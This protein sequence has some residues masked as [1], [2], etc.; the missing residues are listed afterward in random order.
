MKHLLLLNKLRVENAN[1]IAGMTWG[2]PAP[3][4][5]LGFTHALSRKCQAKWGAQ[6]SL[7]GVGIICHH[8]QVHSQQ[9]SGFE[10]VFA[11]SRNPLTKDGKTAPFNEEGRM[12]MTVSLLVECEFDPLE[13]ALGD[14]LPEQRIRQFE[15]QLLDWLATQRL[16]GGI[17]TS[18][19]RVRYWQFDET[20]SDSQRAFRRQM[21]RLIP[22]FVLLD[23][24]DL[25][26]AHHQAQRQ[27]NPA[28][29]LLDS[30][31]DFIALCYQPEPTGLKDG[32]EPI[33]G[34]TKAD[35][36]IKPR[37]GAGKGYLVPLAAGYQ[38]ISE[39]YAAG[40]VSRARDN[41]VPFRFVE[42]AYSIGEWCSPHR[43]QS[44]QELL[45]Q[46]RHSNGAYLCEI[47]SQAATITDRSEDDHIEI[48]DNDFNTF[49]ELY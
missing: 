9:P 35:W 40:T 18:I 15:N 17:I 23:R 10:H 42:S 12:H 45:W 8:H 29:E 43:L 2:F 25:L 33:P 34:E 49:D 7:G 21:L 30:W 39:L 5:F 31:L 6:A 47:P 1:A 27:L 3:S 20:N 4:N 13:L 36:K 41:S 32:D 48:P 16:A 26:A 37:P 22:G 38:A 28:A 46:Y 14:D 24:T 44:P 11:L 19:G